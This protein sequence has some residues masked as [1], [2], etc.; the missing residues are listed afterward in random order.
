MNHAILKRSVRRWPTAASFRWLASFLERAEHDPNVVAVIVIGS[1]ARPNVASDDLDLMVLCH[2]VKSLKEK[3]PVEIDLRKANVDGVEANIRSRQDL[4][5][6]T[7]RFGRPLLDKGGVWDSIT[8]RWRNR[9][10]L[11]DP[12]VALDRAAEARKRMEK[13]RAVGDEDARGELEISYRTHLARAAL[14]NAG[15]QPASRPELSSQLRALGKTVLADDLEQALSHRGESDGDSRVNVRRDDAA[16]CSFGGR[17]AA[18]VQE[19]GMDNA[20]TDI[21]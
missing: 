16:P 11:P 12:T 8:R 20:V 17:S 1:A 9:L 13:M 15:V 7:A 3:A 18:V 10:P 19:L 14:A 4:A 21:G 5:I 6:W 2:D